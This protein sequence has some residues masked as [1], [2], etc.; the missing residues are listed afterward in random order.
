MKLA[1]SAGDKYYTVSLKTKQELTK[2]IGQLLNVHVT[3]FLFAK[4]KNRG[5]YGL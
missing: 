5:M 1:P 2:K 4:Y 3:I